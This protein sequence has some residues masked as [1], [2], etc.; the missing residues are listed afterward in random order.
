MSI[1]KLILRRKAVADALDC[2]Q[3]QIIKFE[4]AGLLHPRKLKD[5]PLKLRM[6]TYDPA[7]VAALAK[8]LLESDEKASA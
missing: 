8:R 7:E 4:R 3:A 2:S 5:G 6:V 1:N